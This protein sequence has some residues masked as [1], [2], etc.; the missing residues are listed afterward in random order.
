MWSNGSAC[1]STFT[2]KLGLTFSGKF[3]SNVY[4]C[5][6]EAA[7]TLFIDFC[8]ELYTTD[9]CRVFNVSKRVWKRVKLGKSVSWPERWGGS[10]YEEYR[11]TR[12]FVWLPRAATTEPGQPGSPW[13]NIQ[14]DRNDGAASKQRTFNVN[15]TNIE[16]TWY[17]GQP[18]QT[19]KPRK[20]RGIDGM[21]GAGSNQ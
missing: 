6:M 13:C 4:S 3:S 14:R 10:K 5:H 11:T 7:Y 2:Y 17:K 1:G 9:S 21:E 19:W 20:H 12:P 16:S 8:V 18:P 15:I